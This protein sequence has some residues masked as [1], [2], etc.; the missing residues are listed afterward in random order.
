[1]PLNETGDMPSRSTIKPSSRINAARL[2]TI[3]AGDTES[4]NSSNTQSSISDVVPVEVKKP[5]ET[6]SPPL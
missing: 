2:A 6:V 4:L 1:M 5:E 3:V